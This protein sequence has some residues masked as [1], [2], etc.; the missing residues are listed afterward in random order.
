MAFL[1]YRYVPVAQI[2]VPR[3][4]A[5]MGA[6]CNDNGKGIEKNPSRGK[7]K[8]QAK[9]KDPPL[10]KCKGTGKCEGT[11]EGGGQNRVEPLP[12]YKDPW[13]KGDGKG[14]VNGKGKG[15]VEQGKGSKG[16]GKG[17]SSG[18]GKEMAKVKVTSTA[19]GKELSNKRRTGDGKGGVNGKGKGVVEQGKGPQGGGAD[20]SRGR[21]KERAKVEATSPAKDEEM[22]RAEDVEKEEV[23]RCTHCGGIGHSVA[24]CWQ[25]TEVPTKEGAFDRVCFML[26]AT[27]PSVRRQLRK[28]MNYALVE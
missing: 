28:L 10:S 16:G 22:T 1:L 9:E 13:R 5:D 2:S 23:R 17:P 14:D 7:V 20:P 4:S 19:E 25:H 18:R 27:D 26:N 11:G 12:A 21:G 6:L 3:A 15:G 8:A 24:H